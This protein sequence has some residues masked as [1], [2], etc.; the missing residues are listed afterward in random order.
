MPIQRKDPR[1]MPFRPAL[2]IFPGCGKNIPE[3]R[4][5]GEG[6]EKAYVQET[7]ACREVVMLARLAQLARAFLDFRSVF[8]PLGA[9]AAPGEYV[10]SR[11]FRISN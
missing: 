11:R 10:C 5:P 9:T 4:R 3:L 2:E 7:G 8:G 6:K 1:T